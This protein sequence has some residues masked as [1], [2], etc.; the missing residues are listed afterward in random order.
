MTGTASDA[1]IK[2]QEV[3]LAY[4]SRVDRWPADLRATFE[5]VLAADAGARRLLAQ[6]QALEAALN[7][8]TPIA[9]DR[10]AALTARILATAAGTQ[11]PATHH[12]AAEATTP[13]IRVIEGG[14][15]AAPTSPKAKP[16]ARAWLP[17]TTLAA[18]LV[19]GLILGAQ[20]FTSEFDS[21]NDL[22]AGDLAFGISGAVEEDVL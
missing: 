2:L 16:P 14:K 17:L 7:I 8:E 22:E 6:T 19:L 20:D 4:G 18:S 11:S 1:M 3:L 21:T 12:A 5:P 15:A 13:H 9:D 10:S